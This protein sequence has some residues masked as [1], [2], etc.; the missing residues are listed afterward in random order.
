MLNLS[1]KRIILIALSSSIIFFDQFLKHKIRQLGGFYVCN[2]GISFNINVS[3]L[4]IWL[5]LAF[6][7]IVGI[8]KKFEVKSDGLLSIGFILLIAGA[9]SNIVDR[10][11][12]GCVI[13]FINTPFNIFPLFNLADASIFFGCALIIYKLMLYNDSKSA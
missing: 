11:M 10:V 1:K 2:N 7:L 5:S 4:E 8:Y 9:F 12:Y 3:Y 6:L 13:D